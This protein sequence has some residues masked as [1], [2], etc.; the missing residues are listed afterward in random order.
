M[1]FYLYQ[2]TYSKDAAKGMVAAPSDRRAAA[3]KMVGS[4]GGTLH[5]MFF[6]FG[7]YDVVALIE[8][9]SDAAMAAGAL[10]IGASGAAS[11]ASTTKLLTMDEAAE[12]IRLAAKGS[13]SPPMG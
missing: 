10:L 7:T 8:A 6:A 5:H 9:P 13:Y 11:G 4:V 12:A 3:A 2:M 1:P